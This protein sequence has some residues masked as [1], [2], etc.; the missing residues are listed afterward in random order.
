ME[1]ILFEELSP[2]FLFAWK[3]VRRRDEKEYHCHDGHIEVSYVISGTGQYKI[4]GEVYD[5]AEGDVM[6]FNPGVY[7]QALGAKGQFT[8]L[9]VGFCDVDM[10]GRKNR[11]EVPDMPIIHTGGELKQRLSRLAASIDTEN[12]EQKPGRYFMLR[13]YLEQMLI[14]IAREQAAPVKYG[15]G[16]A[17]ESVNKKYVT[18]QIINYFEEHYAERISLDTIAE[19]MYLSPYYISRVFKSETGDTPIHHLI[20][21]R[22]ERAME[23]LKSGSCNSIRE[24]AESVGYEDV[25]HFSKLFKK[26]YNVSPSKVRAD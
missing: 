1:E 9:F 5:V 6:I 10:N 21:I 18:E 3:G 17:F 7:H 4:D 25:Y 14:L 24:A 20:N 22:L 15:K 19:N 23:L 26:K 16:Y 2:T 12:A 11:F 8:E 13:T